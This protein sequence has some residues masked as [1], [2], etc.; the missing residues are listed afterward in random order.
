MLHVFSLL[1]L[2]A[3][4]AFLKR[5]NCC[6][7][8]QTKYLDKPPS[9]VYREKLLTL[10]DC[11]RE[12]N[13]AHAMRCATLHLLVSLLTIIYFQYVACLFDTGYQSVRCRPEQRQKLQQYAQASDGLMRFMTPGTRR[14][15][16]ARAAVQTKTTMQILWTPI[17]KNKHSVALVHFQV[18][19]V[20]GLTRNA[21][22]PL[23]IAHM[24]I[25]STT[26]WGWYTAAEAKTAVHK[27]N[28]S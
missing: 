20:H 24:L 19:S 12:L 2:N 3:W 14:Q 25:A 27:M 18:D 22:K 8:K 10:Q 16:P 13:F 17:M 26:D 21:L 1:I 11:S 28:E 15:R 6:L 9:Q 23:S 7:P 4:H 5:L